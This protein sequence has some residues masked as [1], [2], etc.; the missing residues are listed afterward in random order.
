MAESVDSGWAH[1]GFFR[2]SSR[3]G[4]AWRLL[5][6][7][8]RQ[9][10]G[11]RTRPTRTGLV[12]I[13]FS[14]GVGMAAFNT[15]QNILYLGLALLL[16]SLLLSGVLSWLNF[17]GCRWRLRTERHGRVGEPLPVTLELRNRKRR[18][19]TYGLVGQLTSSAQAGTPAEEALLLAERVLP[20]GT[21]ERGCLLRPARRGRH[22]ITLSTLGTSYPFGFLHKSIEESASCEVLV[23]APR[24]DYTLHPLREAPA[25]LP[26]S[27][28]ARRGG[29]TELL[30]LRD[31]QP[32]DPPRTVHWKASA[33]ARRLLVRETCEEAAAQFVL[34]VESPASR[35]SEAAVDRLAALTSTLAEDL[36]MHQQLAAVTINGGP[37]MAVRRLA[38][39]HAVLGELAVLGRA[40]D[41][42]GAEP[43]RR[44]LRLRFRPAGERVEILC[45]G[46]VVGVG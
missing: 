17:S 21:L 1:P 12:L 10:P 42:G 29:G 5:W 40:P 28:R 6:Q 16:A 25:R 19:P 4:N 44:W 15:A 23:W 27:R 20:G 9:P 8:F 26:G 24:M 30:N 36:Y 7:L 13:G 3:A 46:K 22:V 35:W 41:G 14:M 31:Y 11:H 39:L 18:L 45:E 43:P 37:A 32:G 2:G 38:E 33:R 34:V